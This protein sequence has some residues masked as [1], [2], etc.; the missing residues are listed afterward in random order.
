VAAQFLE[1]HPEI[2][3]DVLDQVAEVDVWMSPFAYG[4]ALV[5]MIFLF[6]SMSLPIFPIVYQKNAATRCKT[7]VRFDILCVN[8]KQ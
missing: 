5:T 7:A 8:E 1:P 3:L 4:N 6:A 2:G